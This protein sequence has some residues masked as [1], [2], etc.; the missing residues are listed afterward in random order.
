MEHSRQARRAF[1]RALVGMRSSSE[2]LLIVMVVVGAKRTSTGT[3][4]M[5]SR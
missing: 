2:V 1:E 4:D 5:F 3:G